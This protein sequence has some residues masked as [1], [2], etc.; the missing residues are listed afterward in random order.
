V[1]I[2]VLAGRL[3]AMCLD[4]AI[5]LMPISSSTK[6]VAVLTGIAVPCLIFGK[7]VMALPLV[8]AVLLLLS[9][10]ERGQYWRS[11]VDQIRTPIGMMV[12]VTLVL[13]LPSM[14]ISPFPL[15]SMDAWIRVPLFIGFIVFITAM[16]SERQKA[17]TFAL[18]A[19]IFSS[20]VATLFTLSSLTFLP[21]ALSFVRLSGWSP[22]PY[23]G[24]RPPSILKPYASLAVLMIPVLVWGGWSVGGRWWG[25]AAVVVV[26]L[27]ACVALTYNRSA[28]A[29]LMAI[30]VIGVGVVMVKLRNATVTSGLFAVVAIAILAMVLWLQS[31]RTIHVPPEG[32]TTVLPYWLLDYQRQMIWSLAIDIGMRSPWFGN[33]INVVNLL[34]GADLKLP[35]GDLNVIPAHPHNW[36]VEV[37]AETGAVGAFALLISVFMFCLKL[38]SDFLKSGDTAFLA[39]LLVNVGYWGTG[40]LNTSF[41]SAWW[42]ISYL[43]MTAFCLAGR[44]RI[45]QD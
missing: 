29:G 37:F 35:A 10:P 17:L 40:L 28:M 25:L 6:L 32:V 23:D 31:N 26:G 18:Q 5:V 22:L 12:I 43:L 4:N 11:L 13:W 9:H 3:A 33:G 2:E 44:S 39:A 7:V 27:L 14:V 41:W 8:L 38:A 30:M 36:L 34:P 45:N 42:Q 21:E 19:L 20:A 24:F 1:R 16:L 15:R